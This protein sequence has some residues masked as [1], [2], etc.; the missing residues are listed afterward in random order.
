MVIELHVMQFWS[1]IILVILNRTCA[2]M[3]SDHIS[4]QSVELPSLML[5]LVRKW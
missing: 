5:A 3:I 2:L 4:L 1:G